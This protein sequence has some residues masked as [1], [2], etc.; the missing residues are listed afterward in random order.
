MAVSVLLRRKLPLAL[1]AAGGALA[2]PTVFA[3]AGVDTTALVEA[4]TLEAVR[5]HQQAFQEF[6]D[7][8]DGT[9]EASSDGYLDSVLYVSRL[10]TE[11]G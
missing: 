9:R 4:V 10:M 8:G 2:S 1:L 5:A 6:A 7:A 3:N 11:A